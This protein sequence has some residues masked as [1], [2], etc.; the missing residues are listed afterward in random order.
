[1]INENTIKEEDMKKARNLTITLLA[2]LCSLVF[3]VTA[4]AEGL[5]FDITPKAELKKVA[6][7]L[8]KIRKKSI[9]KA[10]VFE[11]TIK[12]TDSTSHL[13][14]VTVVIPGVGGGE[15]FIPVKGDE[16]LAPQAEGTASIGIISPGF[17]KSGYTIKVE[18]VE[19]R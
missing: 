19:A 7:S 16:K 9:E 10:V 18:A 14:S 6:M 4:M 12:N 8:E 2:V 5:S 1:L 3:S 17:P 15:G 11:V 13:Y